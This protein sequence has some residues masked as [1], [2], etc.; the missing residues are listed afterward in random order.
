MSLIKQGKLGQAGFPMLAVAEKES[1]RVDLGF[2]SGGAFIPVSVTTCVI[3][4]NKNSAQ[5][6]TNR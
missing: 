6:K 3:C 5:S 4:K 1:M 2:S